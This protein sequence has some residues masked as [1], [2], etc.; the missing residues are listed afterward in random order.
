M[1]SAGLDDTATGMALTKQANTGGQAEDIRRW[2]QSGLVRPAP[3][4]AAMAS[5]R[6]NGQ[7]Q[8]IS[9]SAILLFTEPSRIE[10][11]SRGG[12]INHHPRFPAAARSPRLRCLSH[13]CSA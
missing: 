5:R 7:D 10:E 1:I 3:T 8:A 11:C 2:D 9:W 4:R 6:H 12:I 13:G